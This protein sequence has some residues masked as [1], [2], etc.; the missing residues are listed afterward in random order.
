[1]RKMQVSTAG[2]RCILPR[3]RKA[4]DTGTEEAPK[5]GKRHRLHFQT[6]REPGEAVDGAE[7]RRV[8]RNL[9]HPQ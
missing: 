3:L 5:T 8:H 7:E 1:M 6:V 4:S 2:R 9:C